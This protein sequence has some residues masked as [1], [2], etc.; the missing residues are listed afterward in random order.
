MYRIV[1][2]SQI[3]WMG[4]IVVGGHMRISTILKHGRQI[5]AAA[6][7]TPIFLV[8]PLVFVATN[9]FA[10][11]GEDDDGYVLYLSEYLTGDYYY[12][13]LTQVDSDNPPLIRPRM[14]RLPWRFRS[15]VELG[16]ADVSYDGRR[17]VFAA[18]KTSDNDWNIY[19]G[20]ID[21][22]RGRIRQLRRIIRNIGTRDE[23]PRFSWDGSQIVYKCDGNICIH[24][25]S[26]QTD[27][28]VQSWCELWA[29]SFDLS[30]YTVT[31]TKRCGDGSSDRIWEYNL[32]SGVETD[33]PN[34]GGGADRFSHYL[35]DGRI[36][37]SHI[38][39]ATNT[40]SLWSHDYGSASPFHDRTSS[41]DDPYPD[42]HNFNHVAFIGWEDGGY[43]LFMYR[44]MSGDSVRLSQGIPMLAPVLFR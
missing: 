42:K 31:Y 13:P 3:E 30:G 37:Y 2:V 6:M 19:T 41:D 29:P 44:L 12:A 40:S 18:R 39:A 36:V 7:V 38:D 15:R 5:I 28:I 1:R 35:E 14:L 27:P 24:D 17:I 25:N 9:S 8:T 21:V 43:N 20:N 16:N 4:S 33:V 10:G 23:D 22:N 11:T 34:I 32:L 26:G